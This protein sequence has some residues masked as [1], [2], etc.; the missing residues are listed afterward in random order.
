MHRKVGAF[1]PEAWLTDS[2]INNF[3]AK[4]VNSTGDAVMAGYPR[5]DRVLRPKT[6]VFSSFYFESLKCSGM[7]HLAGWMP[8]GDTSGVRN[9]IFPLHSE[10]H[11]SIAYI[12]LSTGISVIF[13]SLRPIHRS[14][15]HA[16]LQHSAVN[17]CMYS[18]SC[19]QQENSHD[20]GV[21]AL[22]Y[23]ACLLRG[24]FGLLFRKVPGKFSSYVRDFVRKGRR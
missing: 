17:L 13:D 22:F 15:S 4:L 7:K 6:V 20:C 14:L 24:K 5:K 16:L 23:A 2:E 1:P 21:Y 18:S 10:S 8:E 19:A 12:D 3:L 11:W 9:L